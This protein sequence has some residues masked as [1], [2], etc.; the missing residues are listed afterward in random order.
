MAG[1][2]SPSRLTLC[3]LQPLL[4]A[5][6]D[7]EYYEALGV[8]RRCSASAIKKSYRS[9]SLR[10]HPDKRAQRGEEASEAEAAQ[11]Q[12]V[13]EAYETLSDPKRRRVYDALGELGLKMNENPA[14]VSPEAVMIKVSKVGD[15]CRCLI[16]VALAAAVGF[17]F[18][19]FPVLAAL[20]IDGR[21]REVPW[22]VVMLPIW[23]I[24]AF[25]LLNVVAWVAEPRERAAEEDDLESGAPPA[26]EDDDEADDD[27]RR[28][29]EEDDDLVVDDSPLWVRV[30]ALV[31]L[32]LVV[33]FQGLA[34]A[35]LDG[36]PRRAAIV[37]AP[38]VLRELIAIAE[39]SPALCVRIEEPEASADEDLEREIRLM[40]Y[41]QRLEERDALRRAARFAALRLAFELLLAARLE[42]GTP[43]WWL[44]FLPLWIQAGLYLVRALGFH[45]AARAIKKHMTQRDDD[46]SLA[47]DDKLKAEAASH[48]AASAL[49]SLCAA[50]CLAIAAGLVVVRLLRFRRPYYTAF[51]PFAPLLLAVCCCYCCTAGLVC[52]FRSVT[53]DDFSDDD[54][55]PVADA[56]VALDVRAP[57][58]SD[59]TPTSADRILVRPGPG[60]GPG[61]GPGPGPDALSPVPPPANVDSPLLASLPTPPPPPPDDA[62]DSP[63][64]EHD[65]DAPDPA[66]QPPP[67][68]PHE[69]VGI[70]DQLADID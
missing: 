29:P 53:D 9:L 24:D 68:P 8:D 32:C 55:A 18:A 10:L 39:L 44:V 67:P 4:N 22:S 69:P 63:E 33:A 62:R 57:G 17:L 65:L 36:A 7:N 46:D 47:D 61:P 25:L 66:A 30:A 14:S 49:S 54:A 6:L 60:L 56:S 3:C 19:Y 20:K 12:R 28:V 58:P 38:L 64:H 2:G 11:F 40:R 15:R 27:E 37:F 26:G 45:L 42:T 21:L 41:A 23:C 35:S 70:A 34:V 13:K 1:A 51:V 16:L 52:C 43:G 59:A 5:E 31:K 48:A 50:I